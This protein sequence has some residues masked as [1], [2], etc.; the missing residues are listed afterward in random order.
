MAG[1]LSIQKKAEKNWF[2]A[3]KKK[4]SKK[5]NEWLIGSVR[6]T[7]KEICA[8]KEKETWANPHCSVYVSA[9]PSP[10]APAFFYL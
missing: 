1:S 2:G 8:L 4:R 3:L 10:A 7:E 5:N 6:M 9:F